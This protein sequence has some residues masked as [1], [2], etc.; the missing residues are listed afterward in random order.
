[1]VELFSAPGELVVMNN[2]GVHR[3]RRVREFIEGRG[4]ELVYLPP[5]S[6]DFIPIEEALSKVNTSYVRLRPTPKR[7]L[8]KRW[9]GR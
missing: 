2:L 8:W 4:C 3:L 5:Y 7:R 6:P 9:A 1:V